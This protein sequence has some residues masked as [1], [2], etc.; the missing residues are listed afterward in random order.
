MMN[1][2]NDAVTSRKMLFLIADSGVRRPS[3]HSFR[4][5]ATGTFFGLHVVGVDPNTTSKFPALL[6][7]SQFLGHIYNLYHIFIFTC[8]NPFF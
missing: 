5:Y 3:F 4:N 6:T 8:H 1:G 7:S 2:N